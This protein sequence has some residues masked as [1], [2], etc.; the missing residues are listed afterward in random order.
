MRKIKSI[1]KIVPCLLFMGLLWVGEA[2]AQAPY[3]NN[4]NVSTGAFTN[5]GFPA[6]CWKIRPINS[7]TGSRNQAIVCTPNQFSGWVANTTTAKWISD[8]SSPLTS[9][10]S[11]TINDFVIYEYDFGTGSSAPNL[12]C[13]LNI[14]ASGDFEVYLNNTLYT[15]GDNPTGRFTKVVSGVAGRQAITL[16]NS[17]H[18]VNG[19]NTIKIKVYNDGPST[20]IG[21]NVDGSVTSTSPSLYGCNYRSI[22][23]QV[24][25]DYNG[26]GSIDFN[27]NTGADNSDIVVKLFRASTGQQI[28]S[29]TVPNYGNY[30]FSPPDAGPFDIK[31]EIPQN[32]PRTYITSYPNDAAADLENDWHRNVSSVLLQDVK[33]N[34]AVSRVYYDSRIE[35]VTAV[36]EY[37]GPNCLDYKTIVDVK[38]EGNNALIASSESNTVSS[39]TAY[40]FDQYH[41]NAQIFYSV[42]NYI[43]P[44]GPNMGY[45]S[46][47]RI[48]LNFTGLWQSHLY[49]YD[50]LATNQSGGLVYPN[51]HH[52]DITKQRLRL[53]SPSKRLGIKKQDGTIEWGRP[54]LHTTSFEKDVRV[55]GT[56]CPEIQVVP[57]FA[58]A[59][60]SNVNLGYFALNMCSYV[61]TTPPACYPPDTDIDWTIPTT[62]GGS[63]FNTFDNTDPL[64][65]SYN[66]FN[67]IGVYS[68]TL[69]IDFGFSGCGSQTIF[70][71]EVFDTQTSFSVPTTV[72]CHAAGGAPNIQFNSG[73]TSTSSNV[74]VLWD[75]DDGNT[76]TLE[77]PTHSYNAP[78]KYTATCT[79][80]FG[81]PAYGGCTDFFSQDIY[82][83]GIKSFD[84]SDLD[85][86]L[87]QTINFP[88]IFNY[89]PAS[90]PVVPTINWNFGD[91]GSATSANPSHTYTAPNTY[92]LNLSVSFGSCQYNK[93]KTIR[94]YDPTPLINIP[95]PLCFDQQVIPP[96]KDDVD[97]SISFN[98]NN[99]TAITPTY[100]WNVT[101]SDGVNTAY[102]FTTVPNTV[103]KYLDPGNYT[104]TIS[105][106]FFTGCAASI[107]QSITLDRPVVGIAVL[108]ELCEGDTAEFTVIYSS[109]VESSPHLINWDFGD[110]L[111]TSTSITPSYPYSEHDDYN[112]TVNTTTVDGCTASATSTITVA[113][114]FDRDLEI[115][116]FQYICLGTEMQLYAKANVNDAIAYNWDFGNGENSKIQNPKVAYTSPGTYTISVNADYTQGCVN[117]TPADPVTVVVGD[118]D[119]CSKCSECIGSFAP[120]PGER[121]VV[122]AWVKEA[123][124]LSKTSY[125][126]AAI[127]FFYEGA[128][129][130]SP[131]YLAKGPIVE[132]WQQIE[133]EFVIPEN[134]SA[135]QIELVN[136]GNSDVFFDDIRIYPFNANLKSFVY[137]PITMRLTA[138]LDERNYATFYE[139]DEDGNLIRVKKE[140]ERGI[141]T[142]Q[143]TIKRTKQ[144]D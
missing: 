14:Y 122:S 139:Y 47:P 87:N 97:F 21:L 128:N 55:S 72:V 29:M 3:F 24:F 17:S 99:P 2:M 12:S 144:N 54:D 70:D 124:S 75:F 138:E 91:G 59:T 50:P 132:G 10:P 90:A 103:T 53:R 104:T 16:N 20:D 83:N 93:S 1:N 62:P 127:S 137:D 118:Y 80:T 136:L 60:G 19:I 4:L 108:N 86:C 130:S 112:V 81:N 101:G 98:A 113:E 56:C 142:I 41:L 69:D 71:F 9:S 6:T 44:N 85:V 68:C 18:F 63:T 110:N 36:D 39:P 125:Q 92:T 115:Q 37:F 135:I 48:E 42:G 23:G 51:R 26:N 106:D 27:E 32:G 143:E 45:P 111:G 78:G 73:I 114:S 100:N 77:N 22:S 74:S 34:F 134:S 7:V 52:T 129:T 96:A 95:N 33:R 88:S 13:N 38:R 40:L 105:S 8:G 131:N 120:A 57:Q 46:Y 43:Q 49:T 82:V 102:D 123:G 31:I 117:K 25:I 66:L 94:V 11:S 89:N 15:D 121:Y 58:C 140:T 30:A 5:A 109:W 84:E 126:D 67:Q 28:S 116:G 79:V 119:F 107:N 76:S 65:T 61:T 133:E 35:K 64:A 141:K